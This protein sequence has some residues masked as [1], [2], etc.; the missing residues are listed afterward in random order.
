M[1]FYQGD[2][3]ESNFPINEGSFALG[4][5]AR[6]YISDIL[7]VRGNLYFTRLSSEE[8]E[9]HLNAIRGLKFNTSLLELSGV[10]EYEP[11]GAKRQLK[12]GK[13]QFTVSPFIYGGFGFAFTNPQAAFPEGFSAGDFTPVEQDI[14]NG[15][16]KVRL[17]LPMGLGVKVDFGKKWI[18]QGDLGP[19]LPF[20]DY[21]D[22][23]SETANPDKGDLYWFG[24]ITAMFNMR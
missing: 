17:S 12:G 14:K 3:A 15:E 1:E 6:N 18:L 20:T 21:L 7:A 8:G 22:G 11:L 4:F 13:K 5:G 23:I 10:L 19:R 24:G 9:G 2:V 16:S